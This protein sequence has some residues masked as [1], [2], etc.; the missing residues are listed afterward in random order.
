[1]A[2]KRQSLSPIGRLQGREPDYLID[3]LRISIQQDPL[4]RFAYLYGSH[5]LGYARRDS[6]VDVAVFFSPKAKSKAPFELQNRL[7]RK[8]GLHVEVLNLNDRT[9]RE[10]FKSGA[11]KPIVLKDSAERAIWEEDL[12]Y[13]P[14]E[15]LRCPEDYLVLLLISMLK[16]S[17]QL[18]AAL[19][20]LIGVEFHQVRLRNSTAFNNLLFKLFVVCKPLEGLARRAANWVRVTAGG[21][22]PQTM[23]ERIRLLA[24]LVGFD[25]NLDAVVRLL[26]VRDKLSDGRWMIGDEEVGDIRTG[27]AILERLAGIV[28]SF[29]V[30]TVS[31]TP[32]SGSLKEEFDLALASTEQ[33]RSV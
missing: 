31:T 4:V 9:A 3:N 22:A 11:P 21:E 23:E 32:L 20:E 29:T 13:V 1:M 27:C 6:D 7:T 30:A 14:A 17:R 26:G 8:V 18:R 15:E 16:M 28:E 24:G 12:G 19:P 5:A 25:E 10:F 33:M 2:Q